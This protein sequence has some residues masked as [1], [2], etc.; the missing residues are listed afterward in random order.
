MR[1]IPLVALVGAL[2]AVGLAACGSSDS[3]GSATATNASARAGGARGFA[4]D[5]KVAA[6]LK[7]AGVTI[8]TGPR[9]GGG[10][11]PGT[12]TNGQPPTGTNGQPPT[13]TNG[14]PP[15]DGR[16]RGGFGGDPAQF[17]KLRDALKQCGVDL[18]QGRPGNGQGGQG[19][20][21]P[22][23]AADGTQQQGSSQ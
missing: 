16:R 13:G 11:P 6:C 8:P 18:P 23:P 9:N 10:R 20:Y 7:K 21:G 17:Q 1:S 22:P 14:Q 19:G 15:A 5:P 4:S 3:G 2:L 12:G